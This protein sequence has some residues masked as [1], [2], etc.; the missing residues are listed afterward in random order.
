[1]IF[2]SYRLIKKNVSVVILSIWGPSTWTYFWIPS[3]NTLLN[4][5]IYCE[6]QMVSSISSNKNK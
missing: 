1:M 6:I 4:I 2:S 5:Y 3:V